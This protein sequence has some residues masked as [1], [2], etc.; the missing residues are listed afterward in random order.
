MFLIDKGIV[1]SHIITL[2]LALDIA[3]HII[4]ILLEVVVSLKSPPF[5]GGSELLL[6]YFE[7]GYHGIKLIILLGEQFLE[8]KKKVLKGKWNWLLWL[9]VSSGICVHLCLLWNVKQVGFFLK[10]NILF[11][12]VSHESPLWQSVIFWY[13]TTRLSTFYILKRQAMF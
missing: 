2:T 3:N 5:W 4:L 7:P 11:R 8:Y 10:E 12:T 6:F 9:A 13:I 1:A